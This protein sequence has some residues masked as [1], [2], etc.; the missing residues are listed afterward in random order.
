MQIKNKNI[1][2]SKAYNTVHLISIHIYTQVIM[3]INYIYTYFVHILYT[4][5]FVTDLARGICLFG[6]TDQ[7]PRSI[8]L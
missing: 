3:Y 6:W 1:Y 8:K 5:L 2:K 7:R 4:P